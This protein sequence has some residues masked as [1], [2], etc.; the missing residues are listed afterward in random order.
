[1]R[2]LGVI[3][4]SIVAAL[5]HLYAFQFFCY[6]VLLTIAILFSNPVVVTDLISFSLFFFFFD[7]FLFSV[8]YHGV[9]IGIS[10]WTMLKCKN[11]STNSGLGSFYCFMYSSTKTLTS[12]NWSIMYC[13]FRMIYCLMIFRWSIIFSYHIDCLFF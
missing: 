9:S 13:I 2:L 11:E 7:V 10:L 6:W 1:M 12:S 5:L 4:Y 8:Q 3:I